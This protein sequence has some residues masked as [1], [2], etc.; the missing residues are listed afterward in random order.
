[1]ARKKNFVGYETKGLILSD[2]CIRV[3]CRAIRKSEQDV[4]HPYDLWPITEEIQ[5][6]I[7]VMTELDKINLGST[8][9]IQRAIEQLIKNGT[10]NGCCDLCLTKTLYA[11]K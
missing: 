8:M 10:C 4:T 5:A 6:Q 9:A 3:L 1:M 2:K 7:S 11:D